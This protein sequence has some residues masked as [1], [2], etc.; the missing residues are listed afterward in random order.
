MQAPQ[1][2]QSSTSAAGLAN[3]SLRPLSSRTTWNSPGPSASS[4]RFGAAAKHGA[5]FRD[6]ARTILKRA[7]RRQPLM[8][9][10]ETGFYIRAPQMKGWGNDVAGTFMA[11]LNDVF[12]KIGLNWCYPVR[13][14][15]RVEFDF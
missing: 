15:M 13:F 3:R 5:R 8:L 7:L 14:E 10:A 2:M 1:R 9:F 11:E 12:A 4:C 6:Q